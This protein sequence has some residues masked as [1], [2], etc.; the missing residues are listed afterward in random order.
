M[1]WYYIITFVLSLLCSSI[2]LGRYR[3]HYDVQFTLVYILVPIVM[4]GYLSLALSHNLEEAI[5]ANKIVYLGGCFTLTIITL[6]IMSMCRV[7]ISQ[8]MLVLVNILNLIFYL[9]VLSIG[10]SNIFY[11]SATFTIEN[12]VGMLHKEYG[13]LH[14][15]FYAYLFI[16][17]IA[18]FAALI[19]GYRKRPDA[20]MKNIRLLYLAQTVSF[21]S[22]FFSKLL[23][24]K[25]ELLPLSYVVNQFI[26]LIIVNRMVLYNIDEL[27]IDTLSEKGNI[28]FISFDFDKNYLGSNQ[29]AKRFFPQLK[30]LR[31]DK[32]FISDDKLSL[33]I[34]KWL[35]DFEQDNY[36]NE[37]QF[38]QQGLAYRFNISYLFDGKYNRGYQLM[39]TDTTE[40]QSYLKLLS[41][42]NADLQKDVEK[43]IQKIRKMNDS[44]IMG[45]ATMVEGRDNSTGGHI[46]RTSDVVKMLIDEMKKD[47]TFNLDDEFCTAVI[48]SA[49]MHDLGKITVDDAILRKPGKL[50][51]EEYEKMK[52]HAPEGAKI[53]HKVLEGLDNERLKTI[54]EN[55]AHY[56]HEKWDGTGYPDG[57]KGEEIPLEARIMA[58]ADFYDALVSKRHYKPAMPFDQA[59]DIIMDGMG[60][61]FDKR[62]EKYFVAA[63]EKLEEYYRN[64]PDDDK[65]TY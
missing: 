51:P 30:E 47:N 15:L 62:L 61:F 23:H 20:S 55:I 11:K 54:A 45:M 44:F 1:I 27:V 40:E 64:Q 32:P 35:T 33:R 63:R 49:P 7:K 8:T 65:P 26:F 29:A 59:Y 39:V 53:V 16:E 10:Y 52:S 17:F 34:N 46:R 13:L 4:L 42:Y 24:L 31:V 19:Y 9:G 41:N 5:L 12:G 2:Y 21:L 57:L 18:C 60:K 38:G 43:N 58:I 3:K 48:K 50:T 6:Y 28:G 56:H 36:K 22:F 37:Q 25:L 14:N